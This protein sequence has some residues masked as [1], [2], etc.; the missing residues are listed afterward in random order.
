MLFIYL[1]KLL[2]NQKIIISCTRNFI[3]EPTK[4]EWKA[5][6]ES[7]RKAKEAAVEDE[8]EFGYIRDEKDLTKI[9][10]KWEYLANVKKENLPFIKKL[11]ARGDIGISDKQYDE[12]IKKYRK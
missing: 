7:F 4:E 8:I 9:N 3:M 11:L 12:A 10:P 1:Y 2:L 5:F 6:N